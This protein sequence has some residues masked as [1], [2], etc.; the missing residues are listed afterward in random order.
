[1]TFSILLN[2]LYQSRLWRSI[3]RHGWPDNPLDRSLVMTSNVFLH[4][5]PVKVKRK[6][7]K[8]SYWGLYP[9]GVEFYKIHP[10]PKGGNQAS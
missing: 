7:L 10:K 5:H 6:S 8:W 3:F 1:M 2:R 9:D 4:V